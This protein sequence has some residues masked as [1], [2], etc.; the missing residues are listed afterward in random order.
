MT[1]HSRQNLAENTT[2][3]LSLCISF[4]PIDQILGNVQF[5]GANTRYNNNRSTRACSV[6]HRTA[7][8]LCEANTTTP[9]TTASSPIQSPST[10][11]TCIPIKKKL[12][13]S[14]SAALKRVLLCALIS[15]TPNAHALSNAEFET[16]L[17]FFSNGFKTY[18]SCDIVNDTSFIA[19]NNSTQDN[20]YIHL[21]KSI[22]SIIVSFT[23]Q[24]YTLYT[25]TLTYEIL[26]HAFNMSNNVIMLSFMSLVLLGVRYDRTVTISFAASNE[27]DSTSLHS[28]FVDMS[29]RSNG[30]MRFHS[31][32]IVEQA[33]T[34]Q[35]LDALHHTWDL[36]IHLLPMFRF[37]AENIFVLIVSSMTFIA[38]NIQ[39][40]RMMYYVIFCLLTMRTSSISN[41]IVTSDPWPQCGNDGHLY[42]LDIYPE[43]NNK[44]EFELQI[45][46]NQ[47]YSHLSIYIKSHSK[48]CVSP[49]Y[50]VT[51]YYQHNITIL[52][53][54][55]E[56]RKE[57]VHSQQTAP[58]LSVMETCIVSDINN[59]TSQG[60]D[61]I[62]L[63]LTSQRRCN[64]SDDMNVELSIQCLQ[65]DVTESM[66]SNFTILCT[67]D[68]P[69]KDENIACL[70]GMNCFIHCQ[71][72]ASCAYAVFHCP[73][74][75]ECVVNCNAFLACVA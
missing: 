61:N 64:T 67:H 65:A 32:C 74:K 46:T 73:T 28:S 44:T 12:Q 22:L 5:K 13:Y 9:A 71:S 68:E 58:C 56:T 62:S 21:S 14:I 59:I 7:D 20:E 63:L 4:E 30:S 33:N 31:K 55:N 3:S 34:L 2:D 43:E 42:Y 70:E 39:R 72:F 11:A 40:S 48:E 1:T 26:K 10:S 54:N 52:T 6:H 17:T 25:C 45:A 75:G 23:R 47:S 49:T 37:A 35:S 16:E 69:C 60:F 53:N 57:C 38:S 50:T 19:F 36:F 66:V 41:G 15:S 27:M 18:F 29:I 8:I 24:L 51:S